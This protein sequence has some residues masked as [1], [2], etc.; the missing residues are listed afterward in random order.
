RLSKNHPPYIVVQ[1]K[2]RRRS[3]WAFNGGEVFLGDRQLKKYQ[4][5]G[6]A[7]EFVDSLA[8]ASCWYSAIFSSAGRLLS[9]ADAVVRVATRER[10]Y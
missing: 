8:C 6:Q 2:R 1:V 10:S 3:A 7:S 4:H 5:A 9:R